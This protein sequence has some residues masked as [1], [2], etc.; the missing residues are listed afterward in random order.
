MTQGSAAPAATGALAIHLVRHGASDRAFELRPV[1]LRAPGSG[2]VR[3]IV[4]AS[5]LN[6]A[7]VMAR[8]GLYPDAPPMPAVLGYEA[9][10]MVESVGPGVTTL[11]PGDRVLAFTRFGGY[12][13][14]LV[15]PADQVVPLP[16]A[17]SFEAAT[18][19]ATQG[20][21]AWVAAEH[22]VRQW[23]SIAE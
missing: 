12:A 21:T 18:A 14:R 19:L 6:Y 11:K 8:L 3:I 17:V 20:A 22:L 10:G 16:A 7:D 23:K 2:E 5:G 1:H 15:A 9:S 4:R 13:N